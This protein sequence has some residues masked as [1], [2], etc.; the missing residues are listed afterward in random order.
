MQAL[1]SIFSCSSIKKRVS[2]QPSFL[3]RSSYIMNK[4]LSLLAL[5]AILACSSCSSNKSSNAIEPSNGNNEQN[6]VE[7]HRKRNY[8]YESS[9]CSE[10]EDGTYS[11]TVGYYNPNSGTSS[12]YYLDVDVEDNHVITI[13][14]NNGGFLDENHIE[15]G[16]LDEDGY[17]IVHG[18]GGKTYEITLDL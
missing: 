5:L 9:D 17:C 4:I 3:F 10:I 6:T 12:S 18:E 2:L 16:E 7:N 11:A 8:D 15:P 1:Y 14:F 13:Y